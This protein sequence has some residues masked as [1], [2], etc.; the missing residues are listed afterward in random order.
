MVIGM[1][2]LLVFGIFN[3]HTDVHKRN[4]EL[5]LSY[6]HHNGIRE[7]ALSVSEWQEPNM[8]EYYCMVAN[9]ITVL[10]DLKWRSS[11]YHVMMKPDS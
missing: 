1:L 2:L 5:G 9:W 10:T 4:C 7:S 3:V 6:K 8:T 11:H